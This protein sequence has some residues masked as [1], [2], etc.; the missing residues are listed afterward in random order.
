MTVRY[1]NIVPVP[2]SHP[3]TQIAPDRHTSTRGDTDQQISA[4]NGLV[5]DPVPVRINGARSPGH[6]LLH[7]SLSSP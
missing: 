6:E 4:V 5:L 2:H 7:L 1:W 3:S